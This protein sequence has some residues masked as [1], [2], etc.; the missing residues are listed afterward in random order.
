MKVTVYDTT[1]R[2][3]S[4]GEGVSFSLEDKLKIARQLD[5][6]GVDYI[7]GG[8]PFSNPKDI[9]FFK[10]I[11]R[12]NHSRI[13]A[14]GSTRRPGLPPE[15]DPN[16]QAL[17]ESEPDAVTLFGK[18][19][20]LHVTE[21]LNISCDQN[22][23]LIYDSLAHLKPKVPELFYDAEHFFDGY[24]ANPEYALKTL[25]AAEA[26][27]ADCLILCDTNGG[28]LP[29]EIEEIVRSVQRE[30][31]MPL[32]IHCHNDSGVAAANT[33]AAVRCGINHVQ[34]TINGY[35]ERCGN[36]NL[37]S[38]IPNLQLKMGKQCLSKERLKKL[39]DVSWYVSELANL[40]HDSRQ[41]YVGESAFA[42]K[43]GI[44]V[45]AIRKVS[46]SYEHI[47]PELVGNTQ[48]V[49]VSEL[50]GKSN[51][52][53]KAAQFGLDVE[54]R[55]REIV[56]LTRRLKELEHQGFQ[57]EGAEGSFELLMREALGES[58]IPFRLEGFRVIVENSLEQQ[59][60]VSEATVKIRIGDR[61][62]HTVANGDG[63]VNALDNALR[64]AL[65][66]F[67]ELA[68]MEL[69]DYKV[70]ILNEHEGTTARTRVLIESADDRH[71]W[72][73]VG[74]SDNIIDASLQALLDSFKYKLLVNRK[75]D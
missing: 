63:P 26:A 3:G 33:L 36:A 44:H 47:Q 2:D 4:Q 51:L 27:E 68:E 39:L 40:K 74:V 69:V 12:L 23:E 61:L 75:P 59:E 16:L 20:D 57:Y 28:K 25:K 1:L 38:V 60:P 43:G 11:K 35:G 42:H 73:T 22:L 31:R 71:S 41:A 21:V 66:S 14:F 65:A 55:S 54:S 56:E 17:L 32:G 45:S 70:R 48:R 49:L 30:I 10:K 46:K 62:E 15:Q 24:T 5:E 50:S 34:G 67:P 29:H 18:S 52:L 64:K 19:W 37:C 9:Q 7:E 6:L 8:W 53:S 72:G 13:T 58:K